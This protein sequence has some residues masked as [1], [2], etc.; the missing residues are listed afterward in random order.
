MSRIFRD[1]RLVLA[2]CLAAVVCA[3]ALLTPL[4][5]PRQIQEWAE[6]A[7]PWF[8]VLFFAAHT[9]IIIAPVPRTV[10]TVA[11]G[12]LFGPVLGLGVAVTASLLSAAAAFLLVRAFGRDRVAPYLEHP[13]VQIIDDRLRRRGWLAVGA[14]RLI[15][16]APFSVVNYSCALSSIRFWPYLGATV[17][18]ILP[19]T[20]AT[21][22][23]AD[24]LTGGTHPVM[25]G[26]SIACIAAGFLGLLIDQRWKP[27]PRDPDSTEPAPAPVATPNGV[28]N[29]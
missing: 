29:R 19:G 13:T 12:L 7:G 10:F 1:R 27:V 3:A 6:D 21:V 4:P 11:S 23:L 28:A 20:A 22:V 26:V 25:V 14:L 17:V 9:L 24:A 18:G 2:L 16:F 5:A 15:A 8:P